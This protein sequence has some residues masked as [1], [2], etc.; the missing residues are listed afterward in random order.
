MD[1]SLT[2][3]K[4]RS[5]D[6]RTSRSLANA[7]HAALDEDQDQDLSHSVSRARSASISSGGG[8]RRFSSIESLDSI[9][10][11]R[12]SE[13]SSQP[14]S[15][16]I[17]MNIRY[18]ALGRDTT[19]PQGTIVVYIDQAADLVANSTYV[20]VYLSSMNDNIKSTKQK[21]TVKH[22]TDDNFTTW[23]E[24]LTVGVP[25]GVDL[26][27]EHF[28]IQVTLWQKKKGLRNP[29]QCLGG[30]S[31]SFLDIVDSPRAAV[32]G[33]FKLLS[34]I[35]GR[36]DWSDLGNGEAPQYGLHRSNSIGSLVSMRSINQD[37]I[38]SSAKV[39]GIVQ[40]S[41]MYSK[42]KGKI[43]NRGTIHLRIGSA[44]GLIAKEPYIKFYFSCKDRDVKSTKQKSKVRRNKTR[45]PEDRATGVV[46]NESFVFTIPPSLP[47][48]SDSRLQV[49][50]W[51]HSRLRHNECTG[52]FSFSLSEISN[53]PSEMKWFNLLSHQ[54]AR[55]QNVPFDLAHW[56]DDAFDA[57][58]GV[59]DS[60]P[61]SP[62]TTANRD[63]NFELG[64]DEL[65]GDAL[66]ALASLTASN[67]EKQD[68]LVLSPSAKEIQA[69]LPE[70]CECVTAV[71]PRPRSLKSMGL[72]NPN[73]PR[74][75]DD[76]SLVEK[77]MLPVN[78]AI[79]E[80]H[81]NDESKRC[82]K[83]VEPLDES[84]KLLNLINEEEAMIKENLL[85]VA[86]TIHQARMVELDRSVL[87]DLSGNTAD[88]MATVTAYVEEACTAKEETLLDISNSAT[89]AAQAL[90]D[91][92][93]K[94]SDTMSGT[95]NASVKDIN[96][97]VDK[98]DEVA[99]STH[100]VYTDHEIE[101]ENFIYEQNIEEATEAADLELDIASDLSD[102]RYDKE[103]QKLLETLQ[104]KRQKVMVDAELW[105]DKLRAQVTSV[106]QEYHLKLKEQ[107]AKS[108]EWEQ[109]CRN[110]AAE[111][112]K[113]ASEVALL[114][115]NLKKQKSMWMSD[116]D[117]RV[118]EAIGAEIDNQEKVLCSWGKDIATLV[119]ENRKL[120]ELIETSKIQKAE[121]LNELNTIKDRFS[122]EVAEVISAEKLHLSNS[123]EK[124]KEQLA[125]E[126][127]K[128]HAADEA[129]SQVT[130]EVGT[131]MNQL[132]SERRSWDKDKDAAIAA[133]K[134]SHAGF[135]HT[136]NSLS[137]KIKE[138]KEALKTARNE[139]ELVK[140]QESIIR[141]ELAH[142]IEQR[143]AM[144]ADLEQKASSAAADAAAK[145]S[146][147][148]AKLIEV[149]E[150][151]SSVEKE[152]E[153]H[154]STVTQ[155]A[156]ELSACKTN[157]DSR[158]LEI[159]GASADHEDRLV[160][161]SAAESSE[162]QILDQKK[163]CVQEMRQVIIKLKKIKDLSQ[164]KID[165]EDELT[166]C[167][168]VATGL[169]EEVGEAQSQLSKYKETTFDVGSKGTPLALEDVTNLVENQSFSILQ[170]RRRLEASQEDVKTAKSTLESVLSNRNIAESDLITAVEKRVL[171]EAAALDEMRAKLSSDRKSAEA[172]IEISN[173]ILAKLSSQDNEYSSQIHLQTTTQLR[174]NALSAIQRLEG[175]L[176][177]K[178][179]TKRDANAELK[180][181]EEERRALEEKALA[182][183]RSCQAEMNE[184]IKFAEA[185]VESSKV[186]LCQVQNDAA[187]KIQKLRQEHNEVVSSIDD[188]SDADDNNILKFPVCNL[189]REKSSSLTS[190]V[191]V[192]PE[193]VISKS[194]T[195]GSLNVSLRFI[196]ST[197]KG[198]R[199]G[200]GSMVVTVKQATGLVASQPYVKLYI[201]HNGRDLKNT[202]TKT[203]T[204]KGNNPE[205]N[206]M[207]N[208]KVSSEADLTEAFRLQISVWDHARMKANECV[209]GISFSYVDIVSA[210][211][212]AGWFSLLPTARSRT[213]LPQF[214]P[215]A[216]STPSQSTPSSPL[217]L[218]N[219]TEALKFEEQP[220]SQSFHTS[221]S[222]LKNSLET[223]KTISKGDDIGQYQRSC[224]IAELQSANNDLEQA[225]SERTTELWDL[226]SRHG[227]N[228]S[229]LAT[230]T[231]ENVS[232]RHS[233]LDTAGMKLR[234]G[235]IMKPPS[236]GLGL[237]LNNDPN[238]KYT[239]V[240]I[241]HITDNGPAAGGD[242]FV[243]D[244]LIAV[245]GSLVLGCSFTEVIQA[246]ADAGSVIV[247]SLACGSDVDAPGSPFWDTELGI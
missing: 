188:K 53:T 2:S 109:R 85:E 49:T 121:L 82:P 165:V 134:A 186:R 81:G 222:K 22:R 120:L 138:E 48:S 73:A 107:R 92:L 213:E 52:G 229:K 150:E 95:S 176:S 227:D 33:W 57:Y 233:A 162:R 235:V 64:V 35:A 41:L 61:P 143:A 36:T 6:Q 10:S 149:K 47:L 43:K 144:L 84:D 142:F 18:Q 216:N 171:S 231:T 83:M 114:K 223:V 203:R 38:V 27:S 196:D 137:N 76:E 23:N 247:L 141:C 4:A 90:E 147:A 37:Q 98:L 14:A 185:A 157:I 191:S 178:V 224:R 105:A 55:H 50:V 78:K 96:H 133:G 59:S 170:A 228:V 104:L 80:N 19:A 237:E 69:P 62:R 31:F 181:L 130:N 190:L 205:F 40:M 118:A 126:K 1:L 145:Q 239:G 215:D 197:T 198:P 60:E 42:P 183:E 187:S 5:M 115:Q 66:A 166:K 110:A 9:Q 206:E 220:T 13:F 204:K 200:A 117:A 135:I 192:A 218:L 153:S 67:S 169:W 136:L 108:D 161:L 11:G 86:T 132:S 180:K 58:S 32:F 219:P 211:E 65:P 79:N 174:P 88:S 56:D 99:L 179:E 159:D 24:T 112:V 199:A 175:L 201:S 154:R 164:E 167:E 102:D 21:S 194:K 101:I 16:A 226:M 232:L 119:E 230:V 140:Q 212:L 127:E 113:A 209:G 30:T 72:M 34:E 89:V 241:S 77:L 71:P 124:A 26:T 106:R 44:Q 125:E 46:Y 146:V 7:L 182:A 207:F 15:G 87:V 45:T 184:Y 25:A 128:R 51:D 54:V 160:E 70:N 94:A 20:K 202:K 123:L 225:L 177:S 168:I 129:L 29:N 221:N 238:A 189:N 158:K 172:E 234:L 3:E 91:A 156:K 244:V 28:R 245:N 17:K 103:R 68:T 93:Q 246:I 243:G 242:I 111:Q 173:K 139:R 63:P 97:A 12:G 131:L 74:P 148:E 151:R 240:R 208:F 193:N 214:I 163:Y 8:L 116:R 39:F 236:G 75:T 152:I 217:T 155:L 195:Y 122:T 210:T 100:R